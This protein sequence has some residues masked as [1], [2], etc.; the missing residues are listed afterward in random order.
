MVD[1]DFLVEAE[2]H[3]VRDARTPIRHICPAQLPGL[4]AV[5]DGGGRRRAP[6]E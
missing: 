4:E 2:Y 5:V 3:L 1:D 6:C